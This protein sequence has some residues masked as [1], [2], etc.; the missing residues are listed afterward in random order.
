M[1]FDRIASR[2]DETRGGLE[3]GRRIAAG[4]SPNLPSTGPV[5]EIGVGTGAVAAGL[6]EIGHRV[7]GLDL[8][9]PM[10]A[11]AR[12]RLGGRVVRADGARLPVRD[13][14]L[15]GAYLVWVL[16]LVP[17]PARVLAESARVLA[18]GGRLAVVGGGPRPTGTDTDTLMRR[19]H[20]A[21]RGPRPDGVPAVTGWAER[22]GLVPVGQGTVGAG[23]TGS[24]PA[25][26]VRLIEERVWSALWDVDPERWERD[27]VPVLTAL[28]ALPDPDR[29]RAGSAR[30]DLLV[31]ARPD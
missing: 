29:V 27:V 24:S 16:H 31:F 15:P 2:Y 6:R 28:R 25:Q 3:R 5:L 30:H 18:A 21:V 11:H 10:L 13:G 26:A 7:L 9:A 8:S 1:P 22:A 19:M 14:A 20:L 17:D 12:A 23:G 4:L